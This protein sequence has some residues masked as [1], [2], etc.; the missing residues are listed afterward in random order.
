[1]HVNFPS[2]VL[3][4]SDKGPY[5]NLTLHNVSAQQGSSYFNRASLNFQAVVLRGINIATSQGCRVGQ[6]LSY[7]YHFSFC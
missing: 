6:K 5:R 2:Q 4:L 7:M 3:V 1:M